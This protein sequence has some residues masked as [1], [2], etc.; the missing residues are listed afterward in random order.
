MRGKPEA[1]AAPNAKQQFAGQVRGREVGRVAN[2]GLLPREVQPSVGV[3][4]ARGL[5]LGGAVLHR[6]VHVGGRR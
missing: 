3:E 2:L 5:Q 1:L 4:A 6:A